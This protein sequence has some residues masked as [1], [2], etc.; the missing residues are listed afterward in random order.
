MTGLD[1]PR[2]YFAIF[3]ISC[4]TALTVMDSALPNVAL[5]TIAQ[6]LNID[7]SAAIMIVSVNQLVLVMTL[8]PMS[9]LGARVGLRKMY[10]LGL[11]LFIASAL[12]CFFAPTFPLLLAARALQ[13]L[14]AAAA[15]S[16]GSALIRSIYPTRQ[17]GR[18]I[19]INTV[20]VASAGGLAPI[21]GGYIVSAAD[22][23]WIFIA[24]A[25]LGLLSLAVG[26][27]ALPEVTG[28]G[29]AISSRGALLCALSFGLTMSG[30]LALARG[31]DLPISLAVFL[32]GVIAAIAFVRR[33]KSQAMP[34]LPIDLLANR[35]IALSFLGA[36][37][38]F[39]ASMTFV[40]SLPFRLQEHF[41]FSPSDV[42][43][44]VALFPMTMMIIAPVA[45]TLSDRYHPAILG[46][47]GMAIATAAM[48]LLA[49]LPD[50]TQQ[51]DIAWRMAICGVGYG[52]F[53]P[54]NARLII[55][56]APIERAASA[57]GMI[58]T[59]RLAGQA[60]GTALVAAL[61]ATGQGSGSS[62]A[63]IGAALTFLAGAFSL[64]RLSSL[65]PGDRGSTGQN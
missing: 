11:S 52:L 31:Y 46:G 38:A 3:A 59:N 58:A 44:A 63:M 43:T 56:A 42:G 65:T 29:Q 35:V 5:P 64:A 37:L 49:H 16:V 40:L 36:Q 22:W 50:A 32:L 10:Q 18:G 23:H 54:P 53:F 19:G 34:I 24:T 55:S 7:S 8:L 25:P 21:V 62:P 6:D 17:L 4:G 14:G 1:K 2:R 60:L 20:I 57:G 13:A 39:I 30:L 12:L 41:G 9:A 27:R 51:F 48:L 33:E 61:F 47:I 45:G 26:Q 15:L 28:H